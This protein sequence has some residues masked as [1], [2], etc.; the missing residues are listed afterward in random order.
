MIG[1]KGGGGEQEGK[2]EK[3]SGGL[4]RVLEGRGSE[5]RRGGSGGDWG[6]E[7]LRRKVRS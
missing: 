6:S 2:G 5:E 1:V 7:S 4:I 3:V